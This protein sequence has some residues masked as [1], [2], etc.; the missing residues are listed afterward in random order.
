MLISLNWLRDY[1]DLPADLDPQDLA[2]RFTCTTAEVETVERIDVQPNGLIAA[3]VL[4]TARIPDAPKVQLV[5]LDVGGKTLETVSAAPALLE[6]NTIV[7]APDGASVSEFGTIKSTTVGGKASAG[8]IL[9]GSALG[10]SLAQAEAVFLGEEHKPGDALDAGLFDDWT[11]EVDNKSI[12]HR[13]DLWGHYGIA[14]EVAAIL[15]LPLK[16]YPVVPVEELSAGERPEIPISIADA[17]ACRRYT[18]L[19]LTGV[20]TQPAPLWM[21]LRLGH[22]GLRP[23]SGLVDLTNYIMADLGQPMHA[24]DAGKVKRI[25]VDW[26]NEG[27]RFRTLDGAEREL[28]ADDLMIQC[29]GKSVAIA[30]VMGGLE[31]EVHDDTMSL[32]LESANF[33]PATIR[34]TATRLGLRTDASARFEKSLDPAHTVLAIQRF[35]ELARPMYADMKLAGR[36]SDCFP[37]PPAPVRVSVNPRHVARAIGREVSLKEADGLLRPLGFEVD[38]N[39]GAWRVSVP[40]FR[41][42]ND[43][44]IEADVTEELAR[45]IGYGSI[46]PDM[47]RVS[48][49][50]FEPNALH[51][52]EQR[53]IEYFTSAHRFHE[54]H[55]Y[56]WCDATWLAQLDVDPGACVTLKNPASAGLERMRRDLMPGLLAVVAKNRFHYERFSV[57][58]VGSVFERGDGEDHEYRHLGLV[59]AVHGKKAE[60]QLFDRLKGAVEGWVWERF[61]QP[62]QFSQGA[63]Q[64]HKPWE[65]PHRTAVVTIGDT[66]AGRVSVIDLALRRAMDEHLSTWAVCWAEVRLSGLENTTR[67]TEALGTIPA[68]PLIEMDVTLLVPDRTRYTEV[69]DRLSGFG[70]P[71]LK[72]IRY[73]GSYQG[74]SVPAG[75]RS[76]TVRLHIGDDNRTLEDADA[77]GFRETFQG[78]LT[79]CGYELRQ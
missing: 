29:S 34:R 35:V 57:I 9:P 65:H 42:T 58:E 18:G 21:Q 30:G 53:T 74:G 44:S 3:R 38:A 56:L 72:T 47:P 75:R 79:A 36:L 60:Q 69:A 78:H 20:P 10:I 16:P 33:E 15:R 68:Y 6:G 62:A 54:V 45:C 8:M 28:T 17:A 71:L 7:Y 25:E 22:I 12:T 2:E 64:A 46:E 24:F 43:I 67:R 63:A 52:L 51:E 5:T 39:D 13:P 49:R 31:T 32:L 66:M 19:L 26:A 76:I 14:R 48:M 37:H 11:I 1:V 40:S 73:V 4:A 55:G 23:I 77:N 59:S 61:A 70:H 27:D 41:A 50:R